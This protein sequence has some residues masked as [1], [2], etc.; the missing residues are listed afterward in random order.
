MLSKGTRFSIGKQILLVTIAIVTIFSGVN[1]FNYIQSTI[2]QQGYD[3]VISTSPLISYA[4]DINTELWLQN[5]QIRGYVLTADPQ[6]LKPFEDS[7]K[8]VE[9]IFGQLDG[10]LSSED[11]KKVSR[12]LRIVINEFNKQQDHTIIARDELGSEK[13]VKFVDATD[14]KTVS[15]NAV[16]HSFA[17]SI[18]KDIN[19][20]IADNKFKTT[21]GQ[22]IVLVINIMVVI[23]ALVAGIWLSCRIS[24]ALQTVAEE[25][26]LVAAGDLRRQMPQYAG[27][28][29]IADLVQAFLTM[30]ANLR[31][32]V[33]RVNSAAE[34]VSISSTELKLSAEQ[35]AKAA[36]SVAET[37]TDVAAGASAQLLAIDKA[38]AISQDMATAVIHIADN[39]SEVSGK[40]NEA[41]MVAA[42][43]DKAVT[44]AV[45]QMVT[46]NNAVS[47]SATVVDRL[48]KSS[49]KLARLLTLLE[50]LLSRLIC[51]P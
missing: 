34:E 39:A 4:K 14:E 48:G 50:I 9:I 25:V 41:A 27:N 18:A 24:Q 35:S 36:N 31:V 5:A 17:T 1:I 13:A 12:L 42:I 44:E 6:Y 30:V 29:E 23:V 40:S 10:M 22:Q 20:Q 45:A 19:L 15:I 26:K 49:R 21:Q 33:S 3:E 47:Q 11:T 38:V 16:L 43:G 37:V 8:R 2:M 51:W 28:D 32:M 7:R 46:I